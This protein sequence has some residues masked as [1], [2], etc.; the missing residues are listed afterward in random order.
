[1][2]SWNDIEQPV[3]SR[4]EDRC[5]YCKMHQSLQG[6]TFH[7]EHI[8]PSSRGGDSKPPNLALACPSYNLRKSDRTETPDPQTGLLV[9]FFNPRTNKWGAHFKWDGF[10]IQAVSGIGRAMLAA[11]DLNHPRRLKIRRAEAMFE[12]FPPP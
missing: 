1:M 2:I 6:A 10:T 3:I 12:L 11:L 9:P 7:V 4:A 5:E 8:T